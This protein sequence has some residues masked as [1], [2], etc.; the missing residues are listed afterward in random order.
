M[1]K[2]L[3]SLLFLIVFSVSCQTIHYT[4]KKSEVP[5]HYAHTQ[6]HHIGLLG[7]LEFSPPV[8]VKA[9]CGNAGWKAVR[10][11]KNILQ[12]VTGAVA[13][14]IAMRILQMAHPLLGHFGNVY[15][16]EEVSVSC[17]SS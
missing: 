15:S 2:F 16:P 12:A 5:A 14:A 6:W 8:N 17:K 9:R 11:Q 13:S 4:N 10:T 1:F 7:L 3:L